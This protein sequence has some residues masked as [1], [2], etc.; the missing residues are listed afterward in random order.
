MKIVCVLVIL[1]LAIGCR[2]TVL[3]D[4]V[5]LCYVQ[6]SEEMYRYAYRNVY[7]VHGDEYADS[8]L[9]SENL[10][11]IYAQK[12][13]T[14]NGRDLLM[15]HDRILN[16]DGCDEDLL[17]DAGEFFGENDEK[18]DGSFFLEKYRFLVFFPEQSVKKFKNMIIEREDKVIEISFPDFS[19]KLL[20]GRKSK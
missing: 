14:V 5:K 2:K 13:M 15:R 8:F 17:W 7:D 4:A 3:P 16:L 11:R 1:L 20:P 18:V 12:K 6:V 9:Y 10:E 19:E